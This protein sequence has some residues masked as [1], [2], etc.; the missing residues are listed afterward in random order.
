MYIST[1]TE[2]PPDGESD[3]EIVSS[4][5]LR[6][7]SREGLCSNNNNIPFWPKHRKP[8][9]LLETHIKNKQARGPWESCDKSE[10]VNLRGK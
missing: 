3:R 5:I 7:C 9:V 2:N 1:H 4:V 8:Q 10:L 6:Q